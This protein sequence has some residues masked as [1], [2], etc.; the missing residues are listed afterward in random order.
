MTIKEICERLS[1]VDSP[2]NDKVYLV[3]YEHYKVKPYTLNGFVRVD[4]GGSQGS[5]Y[6]MYAV[7]EV[8]YP[9]SDIRVKIDRLYGNRKSAIS[10][11]NSHIDSQ[12]KDLE[13]KKNYE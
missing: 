8:G 4:E 7:L 11:L 12:I 5:K 1:N 3:D 9:D 10:A 2:L 6:A 13:D